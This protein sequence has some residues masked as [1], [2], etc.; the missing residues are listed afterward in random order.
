[1]PRPSKFTDQIV[2]TICDRIVEGESLRRICAD[3]KMPAMSTVMEWLR[4]NDDFRGRYARA[5][6]AQAEV[7]DDMI[8]EVAAGAE[9]NPA[10]A[11]V[12]IEAYKWRASKLAPKVYGE[13]QHIVAQVTA[14]V[15][16]EDRL[17]E[18]ES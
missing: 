4:S 12:K 5:R 8:L 18:L 14:T 6:E 7:M 16:H 3:D 17:R 15:T 9:D 10:A 1:M 13:R 11:R 2:A